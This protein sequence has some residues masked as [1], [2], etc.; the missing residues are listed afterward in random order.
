MERS[1][2]DLRLADESLESVKKVGANNVTHARRIATRKL[3]QAA[4]PEQPT[5][6]ARPEQPTHAARPE[7]LALGIMQQS[8]A[9]ASL[10]CAPSS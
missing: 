10:T 9:S 5:H 3:T 1:C 6:A 4:R 2:W 8:N 7:Q